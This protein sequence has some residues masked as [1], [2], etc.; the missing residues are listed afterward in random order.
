[1]REPHRAVGRVDR[2]AAGARGAED[3]DAEIPLVDHEIDLLRL[4]QHRDGRG[5]GVDAALRLGLRHAVHAALE[6]EPREHVAAADLGA[7][8]LEAAE[9]SLGEI[10]DLEPPAAPASI[11]LV[12]AEEVGGEQRRLLAP[13][14][15]A[16]FED[17]IAL[18]SRSRNRLSIM[19]APRGIILYATNVVAPLPDQ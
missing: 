15:G 3:V 12:H 9:P 2:L 6:F 4:G 7:A 17:R 13:G 19:S 1:M 11:A 16:H 18:V 5:G 10:E 14:A 8:F